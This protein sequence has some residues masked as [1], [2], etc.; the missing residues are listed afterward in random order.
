MLKHILLSAF[1]VSSAVAALPAAHAESQGQASLG[2]LT[3][4]LIDLD[5]NDGIA[6]S[7]VWDSS[8]MSPAYGN[9]SLQYS[10]L[11]V[12]DTGTS[13][14]SDDFAMQAAPVAGLSVSG[15]VTGRSSPGTQQI[16]TDVRA[17]SDAY[18]SG[19]LTLSTGQI[20]FT[21]SANTAVSFSTEYQ[22]AG[23]VTGDGSRD[24]YFWSRAEM[25]SDL[26]SNAALG[27]YGGRDHSAAT[28]GDFPRSLDITGSI[29]VSETNTTL[30][31]QHGLVMLTL[32]SRAFSDNV[33]VPIPEPESLPMFAVGMLVLGAWARRARRRR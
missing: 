28:L 23:G 12:N 10:T 24:E 25:F 31:P 32:N 17:A 18:Y 30:L 16:S 14:G 15:S 7:L 2:T 21:L 1:A 13:T 11:D 29:T 20:G 19:A 4:T 3:F 9:T 22:I 5:P 8:P 33:L 6:P 26:D 27:S